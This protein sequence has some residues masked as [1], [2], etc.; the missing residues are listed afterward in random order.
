MSERVIGIEVRREEEEIRRRDAQMNDGQQG[1]TYPNNKKTVKIDPYAIIQVDFTTEKA[2]IF[3]LAYYPVY[4]Q[5]NKLRFISAD[6]YM[7]TPH[8][9]RDT[10]K[11]F[12]VD[13]AEYSKLLMKDYH[14][15]AVSTLPS[16]PRVVS[17]Q[18]EQ[19]N[20]AA[21]FASL[22]K[23]PSYRLPLSRPRIYL[24]A[25]LGQGMVGRGKRRTKKRRVI[26]RR[27][28]KHKKN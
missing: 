10:L 16:R 20:Y 3:L 12:G 25:S 2:F 18:P 22:K 13:P 26:K 4:L 28:R 15:V 5:I 11:Y 8:I 1:G 21:F 23:N 14:G 17:T 9:L 27:T 19:P 7:S 6:R 24:E